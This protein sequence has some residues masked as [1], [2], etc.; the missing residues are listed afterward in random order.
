MSVNDPNAP[1]SAADR[2]GLRIK[3]NGVMM[4]GAL[5]ASITQNNYYQC[6][7][8]S[9][10]F[11]MSLGPAKWWDA[12]PPLMVEVEISRDGASWPGKPLFVGEVDHVTAHPQGDVVE[13]EGRDLSARFIEAKTQEGFPNKTAS[14]VAKLLA[15]RHHMDADITPTRGLIGRYYS[16]DHTKVSLGQFSKVTTEWDLLTFLA[17]NEGFDVY[18]Q[19][20]TLAFKPRVD[21]ASEPFVV[22]FSPPSAAAAVPRLNAVSMAM[23]R[24]LT[25]AKDVQVTVRSW[26]GRQGRAF[27]KVARAIGGKAAGAS[28]STHGKPTTTQQYVV[29]R[30]NL[31]EIEAQNLANTLAA[32]ITLHERI[33]AV[34]QAGE[35]TLTPRGMVRLQGTGTSW[36][37]VYHVSSIERSISVDEGFRQTLRLKNS[38]PRTQTIV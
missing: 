6:D 35:L 13:L 33:V 11:V 31:T 29:V 19:G 34:E 32:E 3:A 23:E 1:Q 25:L 37:Q 5:K 28:G 15:D 7:H 21:P 2:P 24:S 16:Q 18:M 20:A 27:T 10:S 38:S 14:E 4:P 9:A 26:H 8:F 17:Q 22:Q 36:D 12:E 30:P